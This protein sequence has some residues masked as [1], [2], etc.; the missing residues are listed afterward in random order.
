MFDKYSKKN[1]TWSLVYIGTTKTITHFK[2]GKHCSRVK[3]NH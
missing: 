3:L 2:I 1:S